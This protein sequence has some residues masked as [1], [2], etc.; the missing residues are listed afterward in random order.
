MLGPSPKGEPTENSSNHTQP[1]NLRACGDVYALIIYDLNLFTCL[2]T[3][4]IWRVRRETTSMV[5]HP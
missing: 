2:N 3:L 1:H 5:S 4:G